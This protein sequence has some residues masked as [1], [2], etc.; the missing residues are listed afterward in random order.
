MPWQWEQR[1]GWAL[2]N[3]VRFARGYSGAGSGKNNP[4]AQQIPFVGPIPQGSYDIEAPIDTEK[5]GPYAMPLTPNAG[6]QMFGRSE[7]LIHGDSIDNPGNASEGCIILDR[8]TREK[9]WES[10]DHILQVVDVFGGV[11]AL[12]PNA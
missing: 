10:R 3:G 7:F 6:N 2:H 5:H 11:D 4:D 1:T 9:I 12:W 8:F